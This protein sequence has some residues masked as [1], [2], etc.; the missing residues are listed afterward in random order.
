M[1]VSMGQPAVAVLLA[2]LL[3]LMASPGCG[4]SDAGNGDERLRVVTSLELFADM[5]RNVAGDRAE[6]AALLPAGADPHTYELAPARVVDVARAGVVFINGLDLEGGLGDVLRENAGGPVV[7]LTEG[8][9]IRPDGNPH[10]WLDAEL[11]VGYVERILL[12]LTAEDPDGAATYAANAAAYGD[13]LVALDGELESAVAS[14]PADRRKLV[15]FH[16]AFAYLA[17]A[18]GLEL[19]GVVATSPGQEPSARAISDLIQAIRDEGVQ[20][21]FAEPQFNAAILESA[22]EEAGVRVLDL[23]SDAFIDGVETYIELMRFNAAQLVEGLGG[24]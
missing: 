24:E 17:D 14:I 21:V 4:G 20:A 11:A 6:V 10:L 16:N 3:A 18:Y 19:V 5:V 22:A 8:L 23:L 7:E 13:S 1:R 15:T 2:L 12:A 9:A